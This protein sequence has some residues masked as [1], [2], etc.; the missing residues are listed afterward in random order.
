MLLC[1]PEKGRE[2]V[3]YNYLPMQIELTENPDVCEK[4]FILV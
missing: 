1:K 4:T 2:R 3:C